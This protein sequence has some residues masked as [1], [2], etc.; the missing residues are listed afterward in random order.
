MCYHYYVGNNAY[1]E[2]EGAAM[3]TNKR[4][5]KTISNE[6]YVKAMEAI[7]A[8]MDNNGY[9]DE[10]WWLDMEPSK[11]EMQEMVEDYLPFRWQ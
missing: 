11:A 10:P 2:Y 1:H 7:H 8:D 6:D 5:L 4:P 9:F 3:A